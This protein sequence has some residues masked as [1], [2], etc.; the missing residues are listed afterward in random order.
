M[1][2]FKILLS[3]EPKGAKRLVIVPPT[4]NVFCSLEPH[5]WVTAW[6]SVISISKMKC[7]LILQ[8]A[9]ANTMIGSFSQ[10]VN[11]WPKLPHK[12]SQELRMLS[13]VLLFIA[14]SLLLL[15]LSLPS[16]LSLYSY[17][18]LSLSLSLYFCWS[19]HVFLLFWSN[20][21]KVTILNHC[22]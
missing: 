1:I 18:Y 3:Y 2:I 7:L 21:S 8:R 6:T 22:W 15:C 20:V 16:S 4:F 19:D 17:L 5:G 10:K 11:I 14:R 9:N 13:T 12:T